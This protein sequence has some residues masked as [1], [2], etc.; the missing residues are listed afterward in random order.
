MFPLAR[1]KMHQNPPLQ[2]NMF[3]QILRMNIELRAF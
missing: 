2:G 1:A 3:H